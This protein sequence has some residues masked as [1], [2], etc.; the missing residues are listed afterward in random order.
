MMHP[1]VGNLSDKTMDELL[2]TIN[3]LHVRAG[4][5]R[6]I[7][8]SAMLTQVM[9]IMQNYQEEYEKRRMAE[10]KAAEE[11]PIFKDSLDIG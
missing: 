1:L 5:A 4:T 3:K 10:V 11:N 7:G 9:N 2:E 6:R 8:N